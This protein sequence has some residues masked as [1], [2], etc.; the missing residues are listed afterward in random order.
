MKL[1]DARDF[2]YF[3]SGKTSDLVR[4][5]GL[6]GIAVVWLFKYEVDGVPKIPEA[7]LPPLI[8]IVLALA[9]DLLQ[10]AVATSIWGIFQR[11]RERSGISEDTDFLAPKQVNWSSI[12]FF[13]LKT[14]AV[15]FAYVFLL[16]YLAC[17]IV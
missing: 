2:Y 3:Y 7:L 5:L 6:A 1:K 16:R 9:F 15:I 11:S 4:Q 13:V 8:L 14:L 12:G 17:T 10:Y